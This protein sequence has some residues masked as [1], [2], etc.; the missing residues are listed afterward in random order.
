MSDMEVRRA[1]IDD[2]LD[3]LAWRNDPIAI[4]MSKTGAVSEV[5]HRAWFPGAINSPNRVLL[6]AEEAGKKLGMVR[7]DRSDDAWLTSINLAAES[8]GQG[9]GQRVLDLAI[10]ASG[11]SPLLAEIRD[12]NIPSIRIFERCGFRQISATDGWLHFSRL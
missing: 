7:F 12:G 11:C 9:L 10:Q 6:I 2:M 5:Q 1:T 4:A 3:V 8:R